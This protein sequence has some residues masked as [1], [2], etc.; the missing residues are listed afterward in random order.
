MRYERATVHETAQPLSQQ[1]LHDIVAAASTIDERLGEGF[2]PDDAQTNDQIV[3]VRLDAWCQVVAKGDW[4]RFRQRLAWDGL[5]EDT[6][7]RVLGV[8]RV[9]EGALLPA[10]AD[11]LSEAVNLAASSPVDEAGAGK[12]DEGCLP[13]LDVNEPLPFEEILV[14][15]VLLARQ[16]CVAQAGDTYHL[17]SNEAHLTLQRSLLQTLTSYAALALHLE[18]SIEHAQAQ[19]PL[20]RLFILAQEDE[21]RSRYQQFVEHMRR[22]GLAPFSGSTAC[23]PGCWQ[24]SLI[25]GSRLPSSSCSD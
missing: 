13:F 3:K 6:V 4:E 21:D 14:P 24:P 1:D 15:F 20:E 19:P 16:E 2:F 8:V 22:N 10:W 12:A 7:R 18:F 5:E 11:T 25:C 17:L 9:P 23:W